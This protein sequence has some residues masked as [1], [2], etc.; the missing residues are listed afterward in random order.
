MSGRGHWEGGPWQWRG[1]CA[2]PLLAPFRVVL[3]TKSAASG[4]VRETDH[5][6]LA[7]LANFYCTAPGVGL[8]TAATLVAYLPGLGHWDSKALT[9]LVGLAPWSPDSD[10]KRLTGPSGAAWTG[11]PHSTHA[12]LDRD[13]PR[14]RTHR[15]CD[16]LRGRGKP[17]NVPVVP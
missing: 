15:F 9:S 2:K 17:K 7:D 12:H 8:L 14:Q 13:P 11:V 6:T 3:R 5:P 16:R 4:V 1:K 10:K